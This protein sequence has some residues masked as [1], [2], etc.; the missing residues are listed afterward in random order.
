MTVIETSKPEKRIQITMSERR[1]LR[2]DS[3]KWPLIASVDWHDGAVECQ[4][5]HKWT[6]RVREHVSEGGDSDG[7]RIVYGWVRAGNGGVPVGWRGVEGGF[8]IEANGGKPDDSETIRAIR[9]VGEI[10]GDAK[11]AD[12]CIADLPS[13]EV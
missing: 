6:I 7:R 9:C 2:I 3:D 12:E 5:N 1:P 4:A 11:M 13:E 10:I 8:L